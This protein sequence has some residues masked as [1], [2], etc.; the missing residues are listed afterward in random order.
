M[1]LSMEILH[2]YLPI[3]NSNEALFLFGEGNLLDKAISFRTEMCGAGEKKEGN[4]GS[5]SQICRIL[6]CS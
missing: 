2:S 1:G 4:T 5:V 3:L 6:L